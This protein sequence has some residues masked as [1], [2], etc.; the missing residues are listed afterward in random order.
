MVYLF[1]VIYVVLLALIYV[2]YDIYKKHR[3]KVKSEKNLINHVLKLIRLKKKPTPKILLIE[4]LNISPQTFK[5]L[6]DNMIHKDLIRFTDSDVNISEFGK[7]YF[8]KII[9]KWWEYDSKHC[10][11]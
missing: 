2:G 10:I 3:K 11:Y 7:H 5:K 9:K 4:T 6:I 8:D 1:V